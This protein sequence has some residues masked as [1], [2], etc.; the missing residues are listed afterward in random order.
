MHPCLRAIAFVFCAGLTASALC[1]C[2]PKAGTAL[3]PSPQTQ[4][5]AV[6][7]SSMLPGPGSPSP[8]YR[9]NLC[10]TIMSLG[11]DVADAAREHIGV[12][13]RSGGASP[14]SGFDCSGFVY[15]VF[16]KQGVTVPR[17]SVRQS[18]AGQE[19]AKA[20]LLPGDI[21]IFRIANTPNGRHSAIYLGDGRFIHSPS[22][23]SRVRIENL[24]ADY[25]KRH[26]MTARRVLEE[27]PCDLD[28]YGNPELSDTQALLDEIGIGRK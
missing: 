3:L 1:A 25:W 20:D 23:G 6:Q 12:R 5:A 28:L 26:Y 7:A 4:P 11:E 22:A 17:D 16:S 10:P 27:P 21:L 2:Q 13:Y 8:L 24:E 19:V 15:W 18:R 14:S 9:A